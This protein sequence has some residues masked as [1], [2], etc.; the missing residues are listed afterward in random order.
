M[1]PIPVPAAR[2]LSQRDPPRHAQFGLCGRVGY[3][4]GQR[5]TWSSLE[6]IKLTTGTRLSRARGSQRRAETSESRLQTSDSRERTVVRAL[7]Q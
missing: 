3:G 7:Q 4:C 6:S 2:E 1:C 5:I